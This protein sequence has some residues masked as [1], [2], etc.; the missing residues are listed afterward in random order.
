MASNMEGGGGR[1][2]SAEVVMRGEAPYAYWIANGGTAWN[3]PWFK[4]TAVHN[5][6]IDLWLAENDPVA[7]G[8]GALGDGTAIKIFSAIYVEL[9]GYVLTTEFLESL[10]PAQQDDQFDV[11]M[12]AM[13]SRVKAELKRFCGIWDKHSNLI[14]AGKYKNGLEACKKKAARVSAN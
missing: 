5:E 14:N 8:K 7:T 1:N 6:V 3:N 12:R 11:E 10:K 13:K 4:K 9:K 2:N